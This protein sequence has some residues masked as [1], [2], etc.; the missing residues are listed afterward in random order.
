MSL[1]KG[2]DVVFSERSAVRLEIFS[3]AEN[4]SRESPEMEP[5]PETKPVRSLDLC[6]LYFGPGCQE[7]FGDL[8][9][10]LAGKITHEDEDIMT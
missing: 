9:P 8:A 2:E 1:E 5:V 10:A 6:A 4:E 3:M 7:G